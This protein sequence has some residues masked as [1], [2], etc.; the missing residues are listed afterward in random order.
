MGRSIAVVTG[1][2][3]QFVK[4]QEQLRALHAADPDK[5]WNRI[6]L[7]TANTVQAEEY[8]IVILSLVKT[9]GSRGFIGQ[10]QRSTSL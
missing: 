4:I 9:Q 3:L 10:K 6:T 1:Y 8:G 7:V 5:G 2:T